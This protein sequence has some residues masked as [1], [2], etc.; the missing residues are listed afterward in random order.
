MQI[1]PDFAKS[2][3]FVLLNA[4]GIFALVIILAYTVYGTDAIDED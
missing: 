2:V 1:T 4:F 3:L